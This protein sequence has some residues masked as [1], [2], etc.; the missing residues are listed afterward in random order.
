[1]TCHV[2]GHLKVRDP[3]KWEQY[4][5]LVPATLAPFGGRVLLRG[6][7][8]AVLSGEHRFDATVVIA[9]PDRESLLGWHASTAYQDLIALR[10]AAADM[11]LLA[12]E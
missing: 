2:I 8:I 9:F 12:F 11:V 7:C 6:Q 3:A 5:S 4:R 1:M 10:E